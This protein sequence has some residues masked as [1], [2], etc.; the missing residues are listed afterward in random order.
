MS[1]DFHSFSGSQSPSEYA[2]AMADTLSSDQIQRYCHDL[3]YQVAYT[4]YDSPYILIFKL[5]VTLGV[6]AER[7]LADLLGISAP[8]LRR[9]IGTLHVH[10][11]VKRHVNKERL[12]QDSFRRNIPGQSA[13]DNQLRTRDVNYYYL[14]YREFANVTKYRIAMMR[15]AIDD[16]I[17]QEVGHRGYIC[18]N[19][20][21]TFRPLDL[22]NLFDPST[23]A[24]VCDQCATELIEH[25]PTTDPTL[26]T[27]TQDNMQRFNLATASIREI[28]KAVEGSTLPSLNIVAWIAQNVKVLPLPGE[29]AHEKGGDR[30][31]E[32]VV[33]GEGDEREELEKARLAEAQR[34]QNALPVW[35]THSTV[36][37]SA[38]ALGLENRK[39]SMDDSPIK[40]DLHKVNDKDLDDE[41]LDAHYA[42]LMAED[43]AD[44]IMGGEPVQVKAEVEPEDEL[45]AVEEVGAVPKVAQQEAN[46]TADRDEPMISVDG[47]LKPLSQVTDTDAELMTPAEYQAW[48]EAMEAADS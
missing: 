21:K 38:T 17:K 15:K 4:F 45:Q 34:T 16:K 46:G 11:L 35:Y 5:L 6:T 12:P 23:N 30:K 3:V 29:E 40:P 18:P 10:R 1:V 42:N 24:F 28:L 43:S 20:G 9:Y 36:T 8:E 41:A 33:G 48:Y 14:D 27:G 32:I 31:F 47:K 2:F 37:G 7:P 22:S 25:D 39:G 19:D 44:E 13:Q 26:G